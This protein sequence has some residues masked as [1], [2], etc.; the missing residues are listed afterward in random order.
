MD[1][2]K[3]TEVLGAA[4]TTG[5]A[6]NAANKMPPKATAAPNN[7][8]IRMTASFHEQVLHDASAHMASLQRT[9]NRDFKEGA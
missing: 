3:V 4:W 7:F 5:A 1:I 2:P 6:D 9:H 8:L